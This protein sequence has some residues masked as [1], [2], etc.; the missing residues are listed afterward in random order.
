MSKSVTLQELGIDE[1]KKD[2]AE[3]DLS[4]V[5]ITCTN[6]SEKGEMDVELTYEGD[7]DLIAYLV[8][9]AQVYI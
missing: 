9:R 5:L 3:Q 7:R 1:V 4:Y 8:E 2:L 6:P